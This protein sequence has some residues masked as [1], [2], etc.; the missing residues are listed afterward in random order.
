MKKEFGANVDI[1]G[2]RCSRCGYEWRPL[3][4]ENIP[5]TCP[6]CKSPYWQKPLQRESTSKAVKKVRKEES[7]K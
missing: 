3:D 7:E 4:L 1:K 6:K 5:E 2:N